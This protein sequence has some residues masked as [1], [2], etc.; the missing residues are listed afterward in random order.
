MRHI[1]A[2]SKRPLEGEDI[3]ADILLIFVIGVLTSLQE[4]LVAKEQVEEGT[5]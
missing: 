1:K 5:S 4:L 2:V 3:P